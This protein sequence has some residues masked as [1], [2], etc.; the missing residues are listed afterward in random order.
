MIDPARGFFPTR[1]Q[2]ACDEPR[3]RRGGYTPPMKYAELPEAHQQRVSKMSAQTKSTQPQTQDVFSE[4]MARLD[5]M[6]ETMDKLVSA[7][8]KVLEKLL[9]FQG[10]LRLLIPQ[11]Q[12]EQSQ[13]PQ[14]AQQQQTQQQQSNDADLKPED[15]EKIVAMLKRQKSGGGYKG[16]YRRYGGYYRG[17]RGYYRRRYWR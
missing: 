4:I 17:G 5:E 1:V 14:Q 16:G 13:H 3:P 15:V 2:R 8:E 9:E 6:S 12:Q 11:Q 7:M 10:Q